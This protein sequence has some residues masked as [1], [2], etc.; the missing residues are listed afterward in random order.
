MDASDVYDMWRETRPKRIRGRFIGAAGVLGFMGGAALA[1][2]MMIWFG[3]FQPGTTPNSQIIDYW[4]GF[5]TGGLLLGFTATW[6]ARRL[7]AHLH[8]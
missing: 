6:L 3:W 2:Q 7:Y 1:G 4:P 8:S 5:L